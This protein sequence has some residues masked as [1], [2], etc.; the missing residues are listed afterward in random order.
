MYLICRVL[1]PHNDVLGVNDSV[2]TVNT[3]LSRMVVQHIF[4]LIELF[5]VSRVTSSLTLFVLNLSFNCRHPVFQFHLSQKKERKKERNKKQLNQ[6]GFVEQ[7]NTR[8]VSPK[9]FLQPEAY[10]TSMS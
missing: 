3:S 4:Y 6:T 5:I 10:S 1:Q 7:H 9:H 8:S 2:L